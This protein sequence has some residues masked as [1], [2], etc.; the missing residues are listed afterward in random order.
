MESMVARI[1]LP[2]ASPDDRQHRVVGG[3][4]AL[5]RARDREGSLPYLLSI[6]GVALATIVG[7]GLSSVV[8]LP[9]VSM[10]FLL[11]VVFSAAR[12]GILPALLSSLL[13]FLA[14]N[15]F[16]EPFHTLSVA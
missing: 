13:S 11:A 16:I 9:N 1:P 14:Y 5:P 7:L 15:F 3:R 4:H 6:A 12:F 10:V 8:A 2:S